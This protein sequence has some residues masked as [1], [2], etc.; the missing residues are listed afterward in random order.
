MQTMNQGFQSLNG[1]ISDLADRMDRAGIP[2]VP[3]E[4]QR[5]RRVRGRGTEGASTSHG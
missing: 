1:Q 4:E 2:E 5:R 3:R